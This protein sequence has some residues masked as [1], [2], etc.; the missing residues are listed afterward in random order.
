MSDPILKPVIKYRTRPSI[1]I[2][3]VCK[4]SQKFIFIFL[5]MEAQNVE[6][7]WLKSQIFALEVLKKKKS[8]VFGDFPYLSLMMPL[9]IRIFQQLSNRLCYVNICF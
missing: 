1:L 9:K 3:D 7:K 5:L 8:D 4:K 6:M 2:G